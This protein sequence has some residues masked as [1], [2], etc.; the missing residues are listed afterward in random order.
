VEELHFNRRKQYPL[1]N[2]TPKAVT[3]GMN[4]PHGENN[5][6]CDIAVGVLN[7]EPAATATKPAQE[8]NE[9]TVQ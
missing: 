9:Y 6:R 2:G 8:T 5:H 1:Q 3:Q 4:P 7:S